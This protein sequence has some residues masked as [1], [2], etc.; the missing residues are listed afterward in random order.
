[1][2][3]GRGAF[4][5]APPPLYSVLPVSPEPSVDTQSSHVTDVDGVALGGPPVNTSAPAD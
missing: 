3:H 1:V 4:S 2:L 5:V